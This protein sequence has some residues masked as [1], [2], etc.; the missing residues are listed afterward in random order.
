MTLQEAKDS[1][2]RYV[3]EGVPT[4]GFLEAVLAN[5]LMEAVGRAD[6]TSLV[7]LFDICVFIYNEIPVAAHGSRER[8][9]AWL[10]RKQAEIA[11]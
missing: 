2:T 4:G 9:A 11:R 1:I 3:N 7:N 5:D 10:E 8:V 6:S